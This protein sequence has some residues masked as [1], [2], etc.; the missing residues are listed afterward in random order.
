MRD[1]VGCGMFLGAG[2]GVLAGLVGTAWGGYEI[3]SAINDALN[4][5]GTVGRGALD[6]VVMGVVAGPAVGLGFYGGL[7]LGGLSGVISNPIIEKAHNL[8]EYLSR[9]DT[10]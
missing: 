2:I 10:R 8:K 4:I 6:L 3:G 1:D 5:T 7:A 9:K